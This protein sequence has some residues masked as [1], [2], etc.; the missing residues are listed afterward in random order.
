MYNKTMVVKIDNWVRCKN[1]HLPWFH[2]LDKQFYREKH[3]LKDMIYTSQHRIHC[4]P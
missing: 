4:M 1:P 2:Q 3:M